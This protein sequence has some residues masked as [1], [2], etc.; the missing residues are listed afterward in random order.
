MRFLGCARNDEGMQVIFSKINP[1]EYKLTIERE[2]GSSEEA[3][4]N[5]RE[6]LKHDLVHFV[7]E[8][9]AA[10]FYGFYGQVSGGKSPQELSPKEMKAAGET[11]TDEMMVIEIIVGSVQGRLKGDEFDTSQLIEYIKLQGYQVPEFL[12]SGFVSRLRAEVAQLV[13]RYD[14]MKVGEKIELEFPEP[15]EVKNFCGDPSSMAGMFG[16]INQLGK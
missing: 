16:K 5:Y 15:G 6:Y 9:N 11:A 10:V 13:S 1:D 12:D 3:V 2:D 14:K 7:L 4:L 8:K